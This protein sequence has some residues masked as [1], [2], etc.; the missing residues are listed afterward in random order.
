MVPRHVYATGTNG[1]VLQ[2]N[3]VFARQLA[4]R[5]AD[6][7]IISISLNP[8]N[9]MTDLGRHA[10]PLFITFLVRVSSN[11]LGRLL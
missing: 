4:K 2:G 11:P 6:K 8:G 7:G 10:S 1:D 3:V 9:I 5:Y